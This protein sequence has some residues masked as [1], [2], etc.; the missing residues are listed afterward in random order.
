[1][2]LAL[3]FPLVA[4]AEATSYVIL[5]VFAMVNLALFA[6]GARTE[7]PTLRRWRW[8]GILGAALCAAIPVIQFSSGLATG[9]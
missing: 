6:L 8:W 1:M 5:G 4:L 2:V 3:T 7:H 9:H